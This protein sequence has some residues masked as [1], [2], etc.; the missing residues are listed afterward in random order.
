M[1][2]TDVL[3]KEG[4]NFLMLPLLKHSIHQGWYLKQN[5]LCTGQPEFTILAHRGRTELGSWL[6]DQHW[7]WFLL[8]VLEW[9]VNFWLHEKCSFTTKYFSSLLGDNE[10]CQKFLKEKQ[11]KILKKDLGKSVPQRKCAP[12]LTLAFEKP[13]EHVLKSWSMSCQ[14]GIV[15]LSTCYHKPP[16]PSQQHTHKFVPVHPKPEK[17]S[18]DGPHTQLKVIFSVI[19]PHPSLNGLLEKAV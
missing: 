9:M 18:L 14:A 4:N 1:V 2:S 13:M 5:F 8:A 19:L 3:R 12:K 15:D 10:L 17:K 7:L 11:W 6:L 16:K